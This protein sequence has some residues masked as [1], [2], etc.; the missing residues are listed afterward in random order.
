MYLER[1]LEL[2]P[3][4]PTASTVPKPL[5]PGGP[6][7]W[8]H[9]HMMA[10]PYVQHVAQALMRR[11]KSES[12]AYHMA[13]GL[14]HSWAAG[15]DGHGHHVHS[16]VRAAAG[17]NLAKWEELR[18]KAHASHLAR[19]AK[20]HSRDKKDH[21]LAAS[22][23]WDEIA[24]ALL[25]LASGPTY[26]Y[27][28][29][30]FKS[31]GEATA[32]G[33]KALT[34]NQLQQ[35]PSQTVAAGPPLPPGVTLP[36]P[37]ELNKLAAD[38]EG[39]GLPGSDLVRGAAGHARAAAM[40]MQ[41]SQPVDALHM[42]RAAQAG[43]VSA[44]RE[45]NASMIPVANVFSARL[46]PAEAASARTEMYESLRTRDTFRRLATSCAQMIDRIRRDIFHGMYNRQAE[47]RF[48]AEGALSRLLRSTG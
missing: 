48:S 45:F 34:G 20:G 1:L 35:R 16:D 21:D 33:A 27:D 8:H 4:T 12:D 41:A 47:A 15:H 13:V 26:F 43:I 25:E 5:H 32:P 10:P 7:L 30:M 9:K 18:A 22:T 19:H 11:G 28:A 23:A 44:H 2:T 14:M 37:A 38:I 31:G 40:K 3:Q 29:S 46:N 39:A 42:L 36:S 6:G 17:A 24:D